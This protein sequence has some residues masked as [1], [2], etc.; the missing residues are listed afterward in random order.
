M[1]GRR[2]GWAVVVVLLLALAL[3]LG[4]VALT[5][6]YAIVDD[7]RDYDTHARSIAAGDGPA[8]PRA[9]PPPA[10]APGRRGG[11]RPGRRP[12]RSSSPASTRSPATR[13]RPTSSASS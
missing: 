12:I 3:R 8:P 7:A 10:G 13:R 11:R 6:G 5:P 4:Y 1:V 9:R 2:F